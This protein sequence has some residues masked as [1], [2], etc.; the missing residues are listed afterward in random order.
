MSTL[1]EGVSEFITVT[2]KYDQILQCKICRV[3][4]SQNTNFSFDTRPF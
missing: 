1:P 2:E 3:E 4:W